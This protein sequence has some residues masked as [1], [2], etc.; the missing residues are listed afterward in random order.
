MP[1]S[2]ALG[3]TSSGYLPDLQQSQ[4]AGVSCLRVDG[5]SLKSGLRR[6]HR[7]DT[8]LGPTDT[9]TQMSRNRRKRV[10]ET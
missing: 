7:P 9:E 4:G 5:N 1:A 10:A 2:W 3:S 8:L 6:K